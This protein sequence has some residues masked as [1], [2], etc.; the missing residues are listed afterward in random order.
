MH[1]S[2]LRSS[3]IVALACA[4]PLFVGLAM[5]GCA[6]G[7]SSTR[8]TS[9]RGELPEWVRIVVPSGDGRAF[10]VGG[11]SSAADR[12]SAIASAEADAQSQLHLA[13]VDRFGTLFSSAVG[14]ADVETTGLERLDLKRAVSDEYARRLLAASV[15]DTAFV[16]PCGAGVPSGDA[17]SGPMTGEGAA[18]DAGV[19]EGGRAICQAF[20]RISLDESEWDHVLAEILAGEKRRRREEGQ[21]NLAELAD[22]MLRHVMKED[23]SSRREGR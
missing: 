6:P 12:Q 15:R 3:L 22:W 20:V 13:A 4:V 14:S 8:S 17:H 18:K 10:F 5:P 23:P 9:S 7:P 19:S 21:E 11:V 1:G 16:R 2:A